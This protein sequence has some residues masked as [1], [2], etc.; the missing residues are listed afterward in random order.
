MN[1]ARLTT[2]GVTI[3]FGVPRFGSFIG[4]GNDSP[5]DLIDL[6]V[7]LTDADLDVRLAGG[8]LP[9]ATAFGYQP[10]GDAGALPG[11]DPAQSTVTFQFDTGPLGAEGRFVGAIDVAPI[12]EP[13][14]ALLV[15]GGLVGLGVRRRLRA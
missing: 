4:I 9:I 8:P 12:P 14:T 2:H 13:G 11:W 10:S 5:G 1:G 6:S 3:D 15:L 7:R